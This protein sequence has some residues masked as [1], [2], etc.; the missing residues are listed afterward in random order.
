[1]AFEAASVGCV[2]IDLEIGLESTLS[3]LAATLAAFASADLEAD[4][5]LEVDGLAAAAE[6]EVVYAEVRLDA[7]GSVELDEA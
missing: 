1:M 5:G 2:D 3:T 4:L 6:L 7:V